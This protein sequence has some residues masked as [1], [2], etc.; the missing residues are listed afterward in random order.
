[1]R[2]VDRFVFDKVT[3]H[4]AHEFPG[5]APN[6]IFA[7]FLDAD[8]LDVFLGHELPFLKHRPAQARGE[9]D[10]HPAGED[11]YG[12]VVDHLDAFDVPPQRRGAGRDRLFRHRA[13][14][15]EFDVVCGKRITVVPFE[16]LLEIEGPALA[17]GGEFPTLGHARAD[18]AFFKIKPNQRVK[19]WRLIMCVWRTALQDWIHGLTAQRIERDD[20]GAF[21]RLRRSKGRPYQCCE[22]DEKQPTV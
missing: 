11:L 19:H 5:A 8:L 15:A 22:Y 3:R 17:I 4:A 7:E 1:M 18:T 13:L 12:M 14:E 6:R 10:L 16:S 20:Q 2:V 9:V 21:L